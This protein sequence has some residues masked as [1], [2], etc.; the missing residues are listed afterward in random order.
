MVLINLSHDIQNYII[1]NSEDNSSGSPLLDMISHCMDSSQ[2]WI[3]EQLAS[4]RDTSV[5]TRQEIQRYA[6]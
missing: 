1:K 2:V 4:S 3:G 5:F 6:P